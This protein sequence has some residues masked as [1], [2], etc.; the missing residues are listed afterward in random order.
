[1]KKNLFLVVLLC[2]FY[3]VGFTQT[4]RHGAGMGVS[5][6]TGNDI[7]AT[8][9]GT[10]L[11]S[12]R[13]SFME[14]DNSSL[15]VGIPF[16]FGFTGGYGYSSS[17]G[18][19]NTLQYLIHAP[20]MINYNIGAGS[21]LLTEQRFGFFI[22]AGFGITN[23]NHRVAEY[24]EDGGWIYYNYRNKIKSTFGPSANTGVRF[25]VGRQTKTVEV[26][27]SYMKGLSNTNPHYFGLS[28]LFNFN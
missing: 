5:V 15:T 6:I 12:P 19:T 13:L 22:G 3:V 26:L 16:T 9:Y 21:S 23:G 17:L 11:Y 24:I 1:M 4:F 14:N 8:A 28:C 10:L 20:V 27:L 7:D 18:E 25:G 2:S